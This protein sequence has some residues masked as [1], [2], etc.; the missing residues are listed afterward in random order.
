MIRDSITCTPAA[1]GHSLL[2]LLEHEV[3][4]CTT[5]IGFLYVCIYISF[6]QL[7]RLMR[8]CHTYIHLVV[9]ESI[10]QTGMAPLP[11]VVT[12]NS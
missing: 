9:K 2:R 7:T 12:S 8:L 6:W 1:V 3:H 10:V 4:N 11:Q 5:Q